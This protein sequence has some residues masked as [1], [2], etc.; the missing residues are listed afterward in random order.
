[1]LAHYGYSDGSGNYFI[2]IDTDRCNACGACVAACPAR[3]FQV[4]DEDP[5]DPMNEAPLAIVVPEKKSKLRYE[6]SP[7][8]LSTD[9][10]PALP[11]V[12]ACEVCAISHCW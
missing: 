10:R 7:C 3:I 12:V 2:T 11:C 8:K 6:C 4:V 1:M 9:S 5:N